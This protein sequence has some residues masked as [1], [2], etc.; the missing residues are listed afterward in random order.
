MNFRI[1]VPEEY[2]LSTGPVF[3]FVIKIL[4]K[5]LCTWCMVIAMI[6]VI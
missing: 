5:L 1:R 6:V 2:H 3:L 4:I